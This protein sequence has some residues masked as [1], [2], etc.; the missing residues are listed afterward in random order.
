MENETLIE[1]EIFL[2]SYLINDIEFDQLDKEL[3]LKEKKEIG[4]PSKIE[5]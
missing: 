5:K 2:P 1:K 4:N 3:Q